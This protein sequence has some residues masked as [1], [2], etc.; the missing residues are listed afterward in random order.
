VRS[1]QSR[2][3]RMGLQYETAG[4]ARLRGGMDQR[5]LWR[6][7]LLYNDA[8]QLC[9]DDA[10][11]RRAVVRSAQVPSVAILL[12]GSMG[13]EELPGAS[14]IRVTYHARHTARST[15]HDAR[16]TTH[17]GHNSSSQNRS[18]NES[19]DAMEATTGP[20]SSVRLLPGWTLRLSL[21]AASHRAASLLT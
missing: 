3:G 12:F 17:P 2:D 4:P 10:A 16:R 18:N 15:K 11:Q 5:A 9:S 20:F 7:D 6:W 19:T 1:L 14:W 13:I 8:M 21:T